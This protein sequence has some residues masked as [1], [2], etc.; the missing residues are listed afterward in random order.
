MKSEKCG[1]DFRLVLSFSLM[2]VL[3]VAGN[4]DR[5]AIIEIF[6]LMGNGWG[7]IR[8]KYCA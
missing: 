5:I 4:R 2:I 7:I 8:I 1:Y 3:L 6:L